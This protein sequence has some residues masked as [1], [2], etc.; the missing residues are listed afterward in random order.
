MIVSAIALPSET[1]GTCCLPVSAG[2]RFLVALEMTRGEIDKG[3]KRDDKV[4]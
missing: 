4:G 3:D 2:S 1:R